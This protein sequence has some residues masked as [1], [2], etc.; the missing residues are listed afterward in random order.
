MMLRTSVEKKKSWLQKIKFERVSFKPL[1]LS[2]FVDCMEMISVDSYFQLKMISEL[3]FIFMGK[4]QVVKIRI[5]RMGSH[6]PLGGN[7]ALG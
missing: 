2:D 1:S 3:Q 5:H 7:T 4:W 6:H